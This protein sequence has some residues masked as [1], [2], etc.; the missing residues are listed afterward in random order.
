[1]VGIP[2]NPHYKK[3]FPSVF[4]KAHALANPGD[5]GRRPRKWSQSSVRCVQGAAWRSQLW[6][7]ANVSNSEM[8]LRT[9][10]CV[11]TPSCLHTLQ[12]VWGNVCGEDTVVYTHFTVSCP[13]VKCLYT[14]LCL[15]THGEDTVKCVYTTLCLHTLQCVCHTWRDTKNAST[16]TIC[17]AWHTSTHSTAF[18]TPLQ[19]T[20]QCVTP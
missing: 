4:E 5:P 15:R 7:R 3:L 2:M 19:H 20:L 1:M 13:C 11:Y 6:I 16:D 10:K 8:C 18:S 14:P 12:C 9:V 17:P